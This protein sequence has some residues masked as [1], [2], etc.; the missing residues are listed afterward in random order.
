MR[1]LRGT[2]PLRLGYKTN[3]KAAPQQITCQELDVAAC[4]AKEVDVGLLV[5]R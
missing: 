4:A 5:L 1:P 2:L 3:G